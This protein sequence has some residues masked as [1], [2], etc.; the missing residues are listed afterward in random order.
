[1][2]CGQNNVQCQCL[3]RNCLISGVY[4]KIFR[5]L[6]F[7]YFEKKINNEKTQMDTWLK[8]WPEIKLVFPM[9]Q[10]Q[11]V[12]VNNSPLWHKKPGKT[13]NSSFLT[14]IQTIFERCYLYQLLYFSVEENAS[15]ILT[16]V[17]L[18]N[19]INGTS[20]VAVEKLVMC[21]LSFSVSMEHSRNQT[22]IV[23]HVGGDSKMKFVNPCRSHYLGLT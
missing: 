18:V 20:V 21:E 2:R 8:S 12:T 6:E 1:M 13:R 5:C 11:P 14:E 4:H 17:Q 9:A 15:N 3:R 7:F 16:T 22:T 19:V 10:L 23:G